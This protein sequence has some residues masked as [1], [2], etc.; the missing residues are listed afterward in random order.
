MV[1]GMLNVQLSV[2]PVCVSV[3]DPTTQ[4]ISCVN[5]V[6]LRFVATVR[7]LRDCDSVIGFGDALGTDALG[8]VGSVNEPATQ[9]VS[10]SMPPMRVRP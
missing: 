6:L 1:C 2:T 4:V 10:K 8:S 3:N 9:P 7:A 5:D